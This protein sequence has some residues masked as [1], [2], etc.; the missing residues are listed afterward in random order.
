M[1]LVY[2][3]LER[4]SGLVRLEFSLRARLSLTPTGFDVHVL[5]RHDAVRKPLQFLHDGSYKA[6]QRIE[7]HMTLEITC[8]RDIASLNR[9][10]PEYLSGLLETE[11]SYTDTPAKEFPL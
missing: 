11:A 3:Q 1:P 4:I 8:C 6:L 5:V 7:K 2:V 9:L 10:K